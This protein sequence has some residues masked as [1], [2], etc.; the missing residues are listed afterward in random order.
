MTERKNAAFLYNKQVFYK[1]DHKRSISEQ[2]Q[3]RQK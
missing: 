3:Q 2:Y 1:N